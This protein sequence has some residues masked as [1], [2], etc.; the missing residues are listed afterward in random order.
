[1]RRRAFLAAG[2][3]VSAGC[4][5]RGPWRFFTAEEAATLEAICARVIPEDRDPGAVRAGVVN[6]IDIQMTRVYRP[7]RKTYREGIAGVDRQSVLLH[8]RK[9]T[10][11]S[12]DAQDALLALIERDARLKPFFD[13][14]VAHTMQGFYGDPRHG[15]N[16]DRASWKML[17]VPYPP[18][19]GRRKDNA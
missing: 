8:A 7:L 18:L 9:F 1:M 4:A 2:L 19:R 13:L 10:E 15:G 3:T 12:P 14:V 5:R 17:G 16:R 11:L 6:F